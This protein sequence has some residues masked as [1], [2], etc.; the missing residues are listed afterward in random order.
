MAEVVVGSGVVMMFCMMWF[1]GD[2][3]APA[4]CSTDCAAGEK[5]LCTTE[6]RVGVDGPG[7]PRGLSAMAA[8]VLSCRCGGAG[9]CTKLT[10]GSVSMVCCM[11]CLHFEES[12]AVA[13]ATSSTCT[14]G[15]ERP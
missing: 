5:G 12:A 2:L 11:M 15:V 4:T 6:G 10:P 7:A 13:S 9:A 14:G 3:S 8:G 1:S